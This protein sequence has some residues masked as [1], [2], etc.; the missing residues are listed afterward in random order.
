M[1]FQYLLSIESLVAA[2]ESIGK[3]FISDLGVW[4]FLAPIFILWI[5]M[6]V[7]LGE[8]KKEKW[9]FSSSLAN[10]ISFTW[11]NIVALRFIFLENGLVNEGRLVV[12]ILFLF[13]GLVLI[14]VA[15][16]HVFSERVTATISG[17]TPV[18]FLSV[19]SVLW[20]Q[21]LLDITFPIVVDLV[22]IYIIIWVA[23][24]LIK[25]RLGILGEV[26]A[27]KKGEEPI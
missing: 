25:S 20:G 1:S 17:P 10:S 9:G 3:A 26:E 7:Y 22:I 6:E 5:M 12:A 2:L 14:F 4:W 19:L 16:R 21:R 23:W 15:F 27:I 13:Y 18:Y 8:Y 11:I 24:R